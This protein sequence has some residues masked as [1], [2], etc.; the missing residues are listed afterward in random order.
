[1]ICHIFIG[2]MACALRR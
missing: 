2:Q 1:M